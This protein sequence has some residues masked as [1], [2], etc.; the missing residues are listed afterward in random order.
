M[1]SLVAFSLL[2]VIS[3]TL[4]FADQESF[5]TSSASC[6]NPLETANINLDMDWTAF[7]DTDMYCFD[8]HGT[9]YADGQTFQSCGGC[10]MYS[11][12]SRPCL[13]RDGSQFKMFWELDSISADC[14]QDCEGKVIPPNKLVSTKQTRG[15]NGCHTIEHAVCKTN[16]ASGHA[17]IEVNY[18]S[19]DCC[20]DGFGWEKA[21]TLKLEPTTCSIRQCVIGRPAQWDRQTQ[22]TGG[23]NCCQH[24]DKLMPDGDCSIIQGEEVCCCDGKMV[25]KVEMASTTG[26]AELKPEL[27]Y[28]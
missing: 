11:C 24:N 18:E 12:K 7:N 8:N 3:G 19:T 4:G 17:T 27:K 23:C 28:P 9:G 26:A 6:Y 20:L 14:C 1:V 2:L 13:E 22:Y 15:D 25:R 5:N 16:S 10:M 21:G